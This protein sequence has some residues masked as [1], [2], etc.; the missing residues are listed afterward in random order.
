MHRKAMNDQTPQRSSESSSRT[1]QAART[2]I[3]AARRIPLQRWLALALITLEAFTVGYL[4]RTTIYPAIVIGV[5]IFGT[6]SRLRFEMDRQRTYDI[7]ALAAVIFVIKYMVT[8]NNPRYDELIPSQPMG[9]TLAQFVLAMQCLQFFLKRRDDRLPFSFP[10]IGVIALVCATM[11]YRESG[12]RGEVLALCVGFS[13]LSALYCDASRRFIKVYPAR[14]RGRPIATVLVL[15]AVGS[16]GWFMATSMHKYERQVEH[17]VNRFLQQQS[18]T[19]S[20]GFSE[21]STLGSVS[22]KKDRNSQQTALRIVSAVEPGFFRAKAYDVYE[23]RKWLYNTEGRATY[24]EES[25]P[26]VINLES[27]TGQSFKV[28]DRSESATQ[29]FEVWPDADLGDTFAS[30]L[31]TSWLYANAKIVTVD[32]H[33][34]LRSSDAVSGVPYTLIVRDAQQGSI[35]PTPQID[36]DTS[37]QNRGTS[38]NLK[39]LAT[40]PEWARQSDPMLQLA[41][42]LFENCTSF[43]EKLAATRRYFKQNYS[44]SLKISTPNPQR[45]P[46]EWFLLEQPPAHCEYFASGAAVLLRMAGVPCRYVVGFVVS[47]KNQYSGEWV[48]RNEDAHAWVEAYDETRGWVT[49]DTTPASGI[50]DE[51]SVSSTTQL[52]EYLRDEFHRLRIGWQQRGFASIKTSLKSLIMSP[53]GIA[54]LATIVLISAGVIFRRWRQQSYVA[55]AAYTAST[56]T[57]EQLQTARQKLDVTLKRVWRVRLPGETVDR[58]AQHLAKGASDQHD[59]LTQAADWY[60]EYAALR[61]APAPD[62]STVDNIAIRANMLAADLRKRVRPPDENPNYAERGI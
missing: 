51:S 28:A 38:L 47:E 55:R 34:V 40:P 44:Y 45:E 35:Q 43:D 41:D 39:L 48:A 13:I 61:F 42:S 15:L 24:P 8:P 2:T 17:F 19:S 57:I 18:E 31:R 10:G 60:A 7:I 50:P 52:Y 53:A 46:L 20:I 3:A 62:Q 54:T 36:A 11:V 6:V 14:H 58:Y 29:L 33:D 32:T 9:F 12:Q 27:H 59:P 25:I 5:A 23:N 49:V 4:S 1:L 30:P 16:L 56:P 21:S 26:A 22:L 37:P